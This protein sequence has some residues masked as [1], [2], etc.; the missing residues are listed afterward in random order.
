[1][2]QLRQCIHYNY[3]QA[4]CSH[5]DNEL[6][7][8][9][10]ISHCI[11]PLS[12]VASSNRPTTWNT[13]SVNGTVSS[14]NNN[15]SPWTTEQS[16]LSLLVKTLFFCFLHIKEKHATGRLRKTHIHNFLQ[17]WQI[18]CHAMAPVSLAVVLH[19][20]Q[21]DEPLELGGYSYQTATVAAFRDA[22]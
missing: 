9:T 22:D 8:S 1:M 13:Q 21:L 3:I 2:W 4:L 17:L 14:N 20:A 5:R 19:M 10:S 7:F 12:P 18:C 16:Y 11:V 6:I 15:G